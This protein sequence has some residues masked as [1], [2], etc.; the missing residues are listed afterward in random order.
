MSFSG[1]RMSIFF[2]IRPDFIVIEQ[3]IPAVSLDWLANAHEG[4]WHRWKWNRTPLKCNGK[5][6]FNPAYQ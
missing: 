6:W 5:S 2:D 3:W 4:F 1:F